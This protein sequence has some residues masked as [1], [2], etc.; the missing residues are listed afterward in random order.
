MKIVAD[1]NL[2]LL[3][4][5]FGQFGTINRFPGRDLRA[6]HV[7]DADVLLLRSVTR[8]NAELLESSRVRF[9]GTATIGTDH[10]DTEYLAQRNITWAS[11]PGCNADA[12][13]QYSLAMAW[14][15]CER[16]GRD[17]R[18]QSVGIIGHGNVGGRLHRMLDALGIPSVSCDP[19]LS[20]AGQQGFVSLDEALDQ[21]VVSLHVPLTCEGPYPTFHMLKART[22]SRM[23][24][25]TLLVNSS[26]GDVVDGESL[27]RQL[28]NG[29]I[30]AALDVWP[31]EPELDL[32]LLRSTIIS[33]PHIAGYSLQGKHNGLLMVYRAFCDWKGIVANVL[34]DGPGT[35][36]HCTLD[37]LKDAVSQL[38][39]TCCGVA[40]DDQ[41]MRAAL[42][43]PLQES[44]PVFDRLRKHYRNRNDF[45]AWTISGCTPAQAIQLE[46]LGFR[47]GNKPA[48][49]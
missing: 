9:M 26:R 43:D 4:Q 6:E 36:P 10:I 42:S 35:C 30:C 45:S 17:L 7:Q 33:T 11:A 15:A 44:A 48:T 37:G 49:K 2:P 27:L 8:A 47:A 1:A 20:D 19:P 23:A 41:V 31:N 22:L 13:A 3:D 28:E 39:E 16:L 25:G 24:E 5:T 38:L 34:D 12:A 21:P 29:R 32:K 14:L 18:D 46:A 40:G